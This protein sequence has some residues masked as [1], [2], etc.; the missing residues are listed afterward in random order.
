MTWGKWVCQGQISV[1]LSGSQMIEVY[2]N[3][4]LINGVKKNFDLLLSLLCVPGVYVPGAG[5]GQGGTGQGTGFF[6]G[7][8][9]SSD[10]LDSLNKKNPE[11]SHNKQSLF[12]FSRGITVELYYCRPEVL[13][14]R[15]TCLII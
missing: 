9:A 8:R 11:Q 12:V 10:C 4:Y 7:N 1:L 13:L 3:V 5:I 6:P 2:E 14:K 15:N